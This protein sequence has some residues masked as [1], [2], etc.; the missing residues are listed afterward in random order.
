[1]T[2]MKCFAR[3]I[4]TQNAAGHRVTI[5]RGDVFYMEDFDPEIIN[6]LL[7]QRVPRDG[8]AATKR[9]IA[10]EGAKWR[11][12]PKSEKAVWKHP[13]WFDKAL[14]PAIDFVSHKVPLRDARGRFV[15]QEA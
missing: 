2:K 15:H 8:T 11:K 14:M 1:M 9:L 3:V 12:I 10:E 13:A 6:H 7:V 4:R 5:R